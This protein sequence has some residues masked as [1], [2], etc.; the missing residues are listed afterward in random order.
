MTQLNQSKSL[1]LNV[2]RFVSSLVIGFLITL[3]LSV[4]SRFGIPASLKAY[5]FFPPYTAI[6]ISVL[7]SIIFILTI[8]FVHYSIKGKGIPGPETFQLIMT[9]I[10]I[11]CITTA[12]PA[13]FVY[14]MTSPHSYKKAVKICVFFISFSFSIIYY[15]SNR[16]KFSKVSETIGFFSGVCLG[17]VAVVDILL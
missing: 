11:L 9:L 2:K 5:S 17:P 1:I 16:N 13:L 7:S 4:L 8:G 6:L 12:F 10:G 3:T 14:W 15:F